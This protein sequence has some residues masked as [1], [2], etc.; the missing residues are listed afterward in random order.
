MFYNIM[1]YPD[2]NSSRIS[3]LKTI[4]NHTMPDVFVVNELDTQQ[5]SNNILSQALNTEGTTYYQGATFVAGPDDNNMLYYN[6]EKLGLVSER[7]I[8]TVLRD[9]NE[10]VLYYKNPSLTAASDTT[11]FYVYGLHL[12]AGTTQSDENQRTSE[13]AVLSSDLIANSNK[14]NVIV[15]GDFNIYYASEGAY[16]NMTGPSKANL[17]DP[18]GA[19]NYHNNNVYAIHFTQSTR[20]DQIDGGSTGGMDDR[21]DFIFMSDELM[22]GSSGAK[23]VSNSYR[24]VGQD[25][26]RWNGSLIDPPNSSEPSNV[27]NAL[28]YMSDHLPVY[29]EVE[30]GGSLAIDENQKEVTSIHPNP[31]TDDITIDSKVSISAVKIYDMQGR[32]ILEEIVNDFQSQIDVSSIENGSYVL[33]IETEEGKEDKLIVIQ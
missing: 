10:Y 17:N 11:Y 25:G 15:G 6:S 13:A 14:E 1:N 4:V 8:P 23:F 30:V 33:T 26:L 7:V 16:Y 20:I 28:Y 32:L 18:V 27:I 31:A 12:K 29:M 22:D 21:F 2:V 19:G 24:A 5:G 9:I 3:Y